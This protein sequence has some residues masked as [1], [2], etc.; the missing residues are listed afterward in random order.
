MSGLAA[1]DA[2]VAPSRAMLDAVDRE[3]GSGSYSYVIPNGCGAT[4]APAF[5]AKEP[6]VLAAGRAW[7]EAKNV[8]ALCDVASRVDWPVVVAGDTRPPDGRQCERLTVRTLGR[9]PSGEMANWYRRAAIYA[10]PARYEPFGL[11]VLEAA[12]AGCALV[13]GDIP[14]LRENW[15]GAALFVPPDDRGALERALRRLIADPFVRGRLARQARKRAARFTTDR[16]SRCYL[17]VYEDI[18]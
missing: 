11:S 15:N 2:V 4:P 8:A 3:Y 18:V 7:D 14:S 5:R 1:A 10:L 12:A 13:L 9:L 16:M 17:R 6:M